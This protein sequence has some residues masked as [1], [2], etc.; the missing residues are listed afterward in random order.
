MVD[1][2]LEEKVNSTLLKINFNSYALKLVCR[3]TIRSSTDIT[4]V[5][6]PLLVHQSETFYLIQSA[7]ILE[8][9]GSSLRTAIFNNTPLASLCAATCALPNTFIPPTKTPLK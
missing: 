3:A 6:L 4:V 5:S 9:V 7:T 1:S 2:M 8:T